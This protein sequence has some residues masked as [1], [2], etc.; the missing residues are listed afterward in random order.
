MR[1]WENDSSPYSNGKIS[2]DNAAELLD[3]DNYYTEWIH[4]NLFLAFTGFDP[5]NNIHFLKTFRKILEKNQKI[6]KKY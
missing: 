5:Q 1:C 2:R 6:Q 3:S 4:D